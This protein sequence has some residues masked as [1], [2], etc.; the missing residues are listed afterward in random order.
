M[1]HII[2]N[3]MIRAS[4]ALI[5]RSRPHAEVISHRV[6]IELVIGDFFLAPALSWNMQFLGKPLNIRDQSQECFMGIG[7]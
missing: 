4:C 3:F 6:G 5:M 7:F 2:Q 1:Q